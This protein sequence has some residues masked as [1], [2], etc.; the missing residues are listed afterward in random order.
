MK[1]SLHWCSIGFVLMV[2]IGCQI[3]NPGRARQGNY[4]SSAPTRVTNAPPYERTASPE[5]ITTTPEVVTPAGP[6]PTGPVKRQL[7]TITSEPLIGVLLASGPEVAL[8]LP[9]GA[10]IQHAGERLVIPA[11]NLR[12]RATGNGLMTNLTG[13]ALFGQSMR[14]QV[15]PI[16]NGPTFS[17]ELDPPFGKPQ[18]LSFSGQPEVVI[19]QASRK[20]QLI[21]RVGLEQYLRGVLPTEISPNW[22]FESIKAQAVVA[23]SYTLDRYL[24]NHRNP[25]QL[26]WHYT[27]DMAY[28]GLKPLNNRMAV[29]LDQTRG[30]LIVAHNLPVP[31]LFHACS[32]GQTES[33]TN[34][35][36]QLTGADNITDMTAVMP[37]VADPAGILGAEALGMSTTHVNWRV[38]I[39]MTTVSANLQKWTANHPEERLRL[40]DVVAVRTI[41]RFADSNRVAKVLIRHI[42]NNQEID[43]E[44]SA[45]SFRLAVGPGQVRST[46][47]TKCVVASAQGGILVVEGRGFGHGVGMSQVSAYHMARTGSSAGDIMAAFYPGSKL[48]QWWR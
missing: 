28:G 34:F 21:E 15:Q 16:A 39:P 42:K 38:Q 20:A 36:P 8:K 11:G 46:N 33:A 13:P 2:I 4:G 5:P 40:G 26:H 35:R 7:P 19:D 22:P 6:P 45:A 30:Q 27:V 12:V 24:V 23:R 41:N 48:V 43:S 1:R 47:W 14:I 31:A 32:G 29:A 37:S 17:A 10:I 18:L 9:R 25:W 3:T 44:M